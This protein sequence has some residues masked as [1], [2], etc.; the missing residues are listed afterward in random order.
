MIQLAAGSEL[1]GTRLGDVEVRV[2]GGR[3]GTV[4]FFPGGH[5]AA[6]VDCG[7]E[8]YT[9]LGFRVVAFSRPGYGRTRLGDLTA[10][11]FVPAVDERWVRSSSA[12]ERSAGSGPRC[13][14]RSPRTPGSG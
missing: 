10:A 12:R 2:T 1:V 6:T 7:W 3:R 11:R 8:S 4:L 5:C 13:P 9:R 14:A